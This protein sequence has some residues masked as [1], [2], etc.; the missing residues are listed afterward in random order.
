MEKF[1]IRKEIINIFLYKNRIDP[2]F[3][4]KNVNSGLLQDSMLS[5]LLFNCFI[6]DLIDDLEKLTVDML[7][8]VDDSVFICKN[9]IQID[10]TISCITKWW[11]NNKMKINNNKSGIL[12][13]KGKIKM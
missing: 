7:S 4:D 1:K 9:T 12:E 5:P 10:N 6:N 8:Y 11:E 2:W 3:K 13:V